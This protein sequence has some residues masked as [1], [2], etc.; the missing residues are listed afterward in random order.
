M[1]LD[2]LPHLPLEMIASYLQFEDLPNLAS[3]CLAFA[4]LQPRIQEVT[5]PKAQYLFTAITPLDIHILTH[6]MHSLM[7][8]FKWIAWDAK[9]RAQLELVRGGE[10]V[11]AMR[12][13]ASPLAL[14]NRVVEVE[15]HP[16]VTQAG[17]GNL[18]RVKFA[19]WRCSVRDVKLTIVHKMMEEQ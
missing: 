16:V 5:G 4:Y 6:G 9:G 14:V 1:S 13:L 12:I 11:A 17:R 19:R 18:L 10:M 2:G 7:I 15:H 8:T 3:S